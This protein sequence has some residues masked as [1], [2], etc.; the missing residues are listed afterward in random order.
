MTRLSCCCDW[1]FDF[2]GRAEAVPDIFCYGGLA[3]GSAVSSNRAYTISG[4]AWSGVTSLGAT[5]Y[6]GASGSMN[7][8]AYYW[9][10]TDNTFS[11]LAT[12]QEYDKSGDSWTAQTSMSTAI[13][14]AAG[15][16]LGSYGFVSGGIDSSSSRTATEEYDQSGDSWSSKAS[17]PSPARNQHDMCATDTS[18]AY[19]IAGQDGVNDIADNDEYDRS[20]NSWS[21]KTDISPSRIG[22]STEAIGSYVYSCSGRDRSVSFPASGNL[23]NMDQYDPSGDSWTGKTGTGTYTA[24]GNLN[25][26]GTYGY[27]HHGSTGTFFSGQADT[28]VTY[29]YDPSGDSWS[30]LT[31]DS[32]G[33][34]NSAGDATP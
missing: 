28:G 5:A 1:G 17:L 34:K 33:S 9:G 30:S 19:S 32:S 12:N 4:N 6:S 29:K 22:T 23:D 8:L 14:S 24:F 25:T 7:G 20:G 21:S 10:G 13:Y 3:S 31:T 26:D 16:G 15:V 2:F 27:Y 11:I 18:T